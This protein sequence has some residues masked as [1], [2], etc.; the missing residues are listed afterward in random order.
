MEKRRLD[1]DLRVHELGVLGVPPFDK[2]AIDF[3]EAC[4][5]DFG[6]IEGWVDC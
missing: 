1:R 4:F 3:P 6:Y 2:L 5:S